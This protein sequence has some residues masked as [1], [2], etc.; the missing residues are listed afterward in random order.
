MFAA[1]CALETGPL[2]HSH[3]KAQSGPESH[4]HGSDHESNNSESH[5]GHHGD[6]DEQSDSCCQKLIGSSTDLIVSK[7]DG[8]RIPAYTDL[9]VIFPTDPVVDV[10]LSQVMDPGFFSQDSGPPYGRPFSPS[11]GRAPPVLAA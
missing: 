8:L 3:S 9:P 6:Q 10:R 7:A 5:D 4:H 1:L 11:L 2:H